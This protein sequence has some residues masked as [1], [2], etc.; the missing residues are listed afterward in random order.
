MIL[1]SNEMTDIMKVIKSSE[2]RGILIKGTTRKSFSQEE[3][4]LKISQGH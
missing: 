4:L 2:N 1:T 3:G